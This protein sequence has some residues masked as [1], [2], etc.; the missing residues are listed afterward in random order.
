VTRWKKARTRRAIRGKSGSI[1]ADA[2]V[3]RGSG[4][5]P[6]VAG[7]GIDREKLSGLGAGG[8]QAYMLETIDARATDARKARQEFVED[9]DRVLR[10]DDLINVSFKLQD[11][12]NDSVYGAIIRDYI[13]EEA[14]KHLLSQLA[15]GVLALALALLVPGGGWIAAA[16]LVAS[17][18]I[19]TFQALEA[20]EEYQSGTR[21]YNLGFI[22][23]EPSLIWVGVAVVAAAVD[24]GA[25][26]H[27]VVAASKV[28]AD[29]A[30]GLSA[31]EGPLR[32]FAKGEETAESLLKQIET[33]EGL[34]AEV[35]AAM[36]R[37]LKAS[38]AAKSATREA[39]QAVAGRTN[40][41]LPGAVDPGTVEQAFRAL[42]YSVRRHVDTITK[43][44][45]DAKLVE[46]LG[47]ITRMTG[48]ERSE[49]EA[50][51]EE[52]KQLVKAGDSKKMDEEAL[53]GFV[54]R[55][56]INRGTPG[57]KQKL[58]DEMKVWKP[59]TAGQKQAL[60]ALEEKKDLL[61]T[62]FSEKREHLAELFDL[63]AKLKDPAMR[64]AENAS[65]VRELEKE[66]NAL[67]PSILKPGA[68]PASGEIAKTESNLAKL[69]EEARKSQ[70]S[71]YD[72]LRSAAPGERAR[73][74]ALKGVTGDQIG[75]LKTPPQPLQ[76]E[77]IVSVREV[78]DMDG[79]KDLAW[80]DQKAIV[81]MKENLVAM[82]GAANASKGDRT[83]TTWP[84][85]SS[86]YEPDT[87]AKMVER[88]ARVRTAIQEAITA[89]LPKTPVGKP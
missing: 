43:L 26:T 37:E 67:D 50:A 31:L 4:K 16:A 18:G 33:V 52:V 32:A 8:A 55:W 24:I 34:Q 68:S 9:P 45:K 62:L 27:A 57:F 51:F 40:A 83:W 79:F 53:L 21:A 73:D 30:K 14:R 10:L 75:K 7:R 6:I 44:R 60:T 2:E 47:D 56:S 38:E 25:A 48:A 5:D 42:Y 65:R 49:L 63:R 74:A 54:D 86:F 77:H 69:E 35:R 46:A 76:A 58:L 89:R 13:A 82:D 20:I 81:D 19:S 78:S 71:L 64:S 84:Q 88:E 61:K 3:I 39:W 36:A 29:S 11:I 12:E 66:L 28:L 17:A 80:S 22:Q 23:D 1:K 87:I 72:R 59:L 85:A 15:I 70:L 41:F